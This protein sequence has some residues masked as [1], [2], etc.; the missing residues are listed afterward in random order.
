MKAVLRHRLA[1][2]IFINSAALS[3]AS[4]FLWTLWDQGGFSNIGLGGFLYNLLSPSIWVL[5]AINWVVGVLPV[6]VL[7]KTYLTGE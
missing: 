2:N 3:W 7:R 6:I 5:S 4:T 1:F